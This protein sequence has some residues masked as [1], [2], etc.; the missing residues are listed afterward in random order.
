MKN[1][2][3]QD[4]T[5]NFNTFFVKIFFDRKPSAIE[6]LRDDRKY[7]IFLG[8]YVKKIVAAIKMLSDSNLDVIK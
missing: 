6:K 1:H 4:L 8:S 7:E 5:F 2:L 3:V